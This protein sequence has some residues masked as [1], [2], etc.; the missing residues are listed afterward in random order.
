M[1][2]IKINKLY[3]S[4]GYNAYKNYEIKII[5]IKDERVIQKR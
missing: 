4:Y 2:T 1:K 3:I 5:K